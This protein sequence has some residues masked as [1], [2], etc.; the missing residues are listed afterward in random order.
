VPHLP[1]FFSS[2]LYNGQSPSEHLDKLSCSAQNHALPLSHDD[3]EMRDSPQL[4]G[5]I[6]IRIVVVPAFFPQVR[7]AVG[8]LR[9]LFGPVFNGEILKLVVFFEDGGL[10]LVGVEGLFGGFGVGDGGCGVFGG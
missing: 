3:R 5:K 7:I 10:L 2:S 6:L 4:H 9:L 8:N 1:S